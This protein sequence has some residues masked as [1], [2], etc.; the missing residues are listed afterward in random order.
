M[1]LKKGDTVQIIAGKDKGKTG[2]IIRNYPTKGRVSVEGINV[3][4]KHVKPKREGEK[5]EIVEI[6][7]SINASNLALLCPGC[8]KPTRLGIKKEE[9]GS[10]KRFCKKCD[11]VIN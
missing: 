5:G 2:K 4:K 1:K 6:S 8:S 3:Y 11:K 7:R 9:D 10:K